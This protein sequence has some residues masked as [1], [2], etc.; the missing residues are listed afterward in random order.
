M[1]DSRKG[2]EDMA[3]EEDGAGA[4]ESKKWECMVCMYIYIY[5]WEVAVEEEDR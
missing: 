1:E 5:I 2:K 3:R 4:G